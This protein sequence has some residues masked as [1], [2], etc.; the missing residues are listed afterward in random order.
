MF[1]AYHDKNWFYN[2][3]IQVNIRL[4]ILFL[5][6]LKISKNRDII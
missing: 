1:F 2:K 4:I 6:T 5:E 3:N